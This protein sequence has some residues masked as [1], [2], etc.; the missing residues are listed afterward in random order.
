[1][2]IANLPILR[3]KKKFLNLLFLSFPNVPSPPPPVALERF[4][5]EN[6]EK[7]PVPDSMNT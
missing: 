4:R 3:E 7:G 1:M 2:L 6:N 5:Q